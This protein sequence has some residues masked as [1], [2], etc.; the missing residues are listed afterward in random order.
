[1]PLNSMFRLIRRQRHEMLWDSAYVESFRHA[2]DILA[3]RLMNDRDAPYKGVYIPMLF[4][5]RHYLEVRIKQTISELEPLLRTSVRG[6]SMHI[7][8]DVLGCHDLEKLWDT[9]E[10]LICV[11]F[12]ES[13]RH[14]GPIDLVRQIVDFFH[15][16]DPTGQ[17]FRYRHDKRSRSA[18]EEKLPPGLDYDELKGAIHKACHYF[19]GLED[20][21]QLKLDAISQE[22]CV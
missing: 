3:D 17:T 12:A 16:H 7:E 2:G 22:N 6:H 20:M 11:V 13:E 18:N 8:K 15:Q 19:Q 10:E 14:G 1:M 21:K 4:L 5:Y 9:A